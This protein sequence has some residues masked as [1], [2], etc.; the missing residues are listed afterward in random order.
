[1]TNFLR[2]NQERS[3]EILVGFDLLDVG[4]LHGLMGAGLPAGAGSAAADAGRSA[5]PA[6]GVVDSPGRFAVS[7][8]LAVDV[9]GIGTT[10]RSFL[11]CL[12]AATSSLVVVSGF[13]CAGSF[14]A[15]SLFGAAPLSKYPGLIS[16]NASSRNFVRSS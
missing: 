14:Q 15:V 10:Q 2:A 1:F 12:R 8:F 5:L 7:T 3:R 11:L 13:N 4:R 16:R 9:P 6:A